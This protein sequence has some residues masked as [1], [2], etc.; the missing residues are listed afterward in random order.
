MNIV[1]MKFCINCIKVLCVIGY[2]CEI[3]EIG[4]RY[5]HCS[6]WMW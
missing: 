6:F 3:A 5:C 1:S 4:H 2:L